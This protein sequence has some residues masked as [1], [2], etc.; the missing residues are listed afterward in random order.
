[1]GLQEDSGGWAV[2]SE[3]I[4]SP[5]GGDTSG[6]GLTPVRVVRIQGLTLSSLTEEWVVS[7]IW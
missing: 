2:V 4:V 1:M 5:M 6:V 7:K 3:G